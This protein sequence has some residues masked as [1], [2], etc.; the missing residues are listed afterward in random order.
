M[1]P[2]LVQEATRLVGVEFVKA[3]HQTRGGHVVAKRANHEAVELRAHGATKGTYVGVLMDRGPELVA[4]LLGVLACG[5]AYVP[6]DAVYPT[7]RL[8]AMLEDSKAPVTG[9]TARLKAKRLPEFACLCVE[10]LD[11]SGDQP[12]CPDAEDESEM[13][14]GPDLGRTTRED[15][16]A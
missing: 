7:S 3:R 13:W 9:T 8:E 14:F 15:T 16:R 12:V 2:V 4:A 1:V 10:G 5:A 6:L 11:L